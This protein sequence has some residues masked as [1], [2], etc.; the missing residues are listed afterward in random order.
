MPTFPENTESQSISTAQSY[1]HDISLGHSRLPIVHSIS[2]S[3][4]EAMGFIKYGIET[5]GQSI[6]TTYKRGQD[7]VTYNG[8]N[9]L[10]NSKKVRFN[11]Q[12][13]GE[14]NIDE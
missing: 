4:L 11:E 1:K 12:I 2:G 14:I 3:S 13:T 6:I 9:F 10:F 7:V 8:T 5:K